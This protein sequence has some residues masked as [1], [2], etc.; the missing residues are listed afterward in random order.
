M[1]FRLKMLVKMVTKSNPQQ[2]ACLSGWSPYNASIIIP[3]AS[4]LKS[5]IFMY[6]RRKRASDLCP[7]VFF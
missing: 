5:R 4:S 7:L 6:L 1:Q 3:I 2:S